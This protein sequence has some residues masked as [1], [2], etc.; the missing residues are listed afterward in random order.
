MVENRIKERRKELGL[1][2]EQ[3]SEKSGISQSAISEIENGVHLPNVDVYKR[4]DRGWTPGN[5][6]FFAT[7]VLLAGASAYF[8]RI[9]FSPWTGKREEEGLTPRQSVSLLILGGTVLITLSKLTLF[10]DI[11]LGRAAA[12]VAVM[13]VAYKAGMGPGAA[14]G[15]AAGV[16]MDLAA[17]GTPFYSMAYA[18]SLIHI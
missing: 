6:I 12:A 3:L 9:A 10:G 1:T 16:G 18:L 5:L 17:G 2:Q 11:S 15:V 13:A 4:Q 8:Y 7:E 14:V